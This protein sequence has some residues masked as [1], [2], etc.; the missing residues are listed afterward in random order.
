M[1]SQM[2]GNGR[3]ENDNKGMNTN[4]VNTPGSNTARMNKF[5]KDQ[6]KD[7][8]WAEKKMVTTLPAMHNASTTQELKNAFAS[9]LDQT[10][11]HVGRLEKV[12]KMIGE[13]AEA[14][15]CPAMDCIVTE[16]ENIISET[17][18]D[19]AQRDVGLIFAG[20]KAEH[21][22]IASYGGLTALAKKLGKDDVA[23][24]LHK[25]LT[26]EKEA[27]KLLTEIAEK[28]IS[29]KTSREPVEV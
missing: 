14:A 26:E 16:G 28:Y 8:Y 27:D 13:K 18:N 17:H 6:L 21:Y 5:F 20:Q 9:H 1:N 25:T 4:G 10:K 11:Q 22:E 3:S 23:D 24:L 19:S 2:N 7:I 15:K 29:Y 12:F